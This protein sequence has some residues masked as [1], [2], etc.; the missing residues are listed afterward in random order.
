[1]NADLRYRYVQPVNAKA[2]A[3]GRMTKNGRFR[4]RR[5]VWGR[6]L[7]RVEKRTGE[8]I[9]QARILVQAPQQTTNR[10]RAKLPSQPTMKKRA[11][12]ANQNPYPV[13]GQMCQQTKNR[14]RVI[15]HSNPNT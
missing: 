13:A 15:S 3:I 5:V 7:A 6:L 14:Q 9:R 8:S 4:I 1:M 11:R 2:W 10:E 12:C